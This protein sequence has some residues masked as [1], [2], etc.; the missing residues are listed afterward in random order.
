M[1]NKLIYLAIL[2]TALFFVACQK[3]N[4][5]DVS[6]NASESSSMRIAT[7]P[8]IVQWQRCFG[9]SANEDALGNVIAPAPGGGYIIAGNTLGNNGD[10]SGNHGLSDAWIIKMNSSNGV[11]WKYTY[12]GTNSDYAYAV[13]TTSDGGYIFAGQSKSTDGDVAVNKGGFDVWVVKLDGVG[14]RQW[15]TTLGGSANDAANAV[16]QTSDGGYLIA[17]HTLSTDGDVTGSHGGD[18]A[19]II[20]LD[21]S[22]NLVWQKTYGGSGADAAGFILPS[23][24]GNFMISAS[25][26]SI[27]GDISTLVHH[28]GKDAWLF[29]IDGIGNIVWQKTYGGSGSEGTGSIFNTS[30]GGYIF[31]TVSSSNNGDVSGNHGYYDTWVAKITSAGDIAWQKCYGGTDMDAANV[32]DINS[33][34]QILVA[35]YSFSR[36]GKNSDITATKGGEDFWTLLLD[37]QGQILYSKNAGGSS[38]DTGEGAI[39]MQ[40]GS[41][42]GVGR[43]SSNDGDVSGNHG[44]SDIWVVRFKF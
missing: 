12:G 6:T 4:V 32:R 25:S 27:D 42:I 30:D 17:A 10:V 43:T 2:F 29:K 31:S 18:E 24:D 39:A 21:G 40:D 23:P 7:T 34:G 44:S 13:T 3:L 16:I 26:E 33:S 22:G 11:D 41:Y 37:P 1:K 8:S 5:T 28:G 38:S 19:W 36:V 35:G 20:K 9:S 14:N 15:Q